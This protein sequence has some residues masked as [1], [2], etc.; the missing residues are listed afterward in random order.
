MKNSLL[1]DL[2]RRGL[3]AQT[4]KL[5]SVS[6]QL[7]AASVVYCGFDPT[8]G[9][10]HVGHLVP[11]VMLKRFAD[12]GHKAI[13][14]IG[15]A[16]GMIGDPSFKAT[17]RG[18]N[19]AEQVSKWTQS[20]AAQIERIL[21]PELNHD[22]TIV[23]NSEWFKQLDIITFFR[24]VGKHFAVNAMLNRDSVKQRLSRENQG[25]S[26][27]EFSY[28]L[29]QAYD[30]VHLNK[31]YQCTVQIGGSDQ[32]GNL[33]DGVDLTRRLN[34]QEVHGITLPLITKSDGTKFGKS[35][36]GTVWLDPNK[37]SPYA[38][39]QFWLNVAD[40]DV[41][42]FLRYYTFLSPQ[43]IDSVEQK[44]KSSGT[45]PVAQSLLAKILTRFVHGTVGLDSAERIT[46][47]LFTGDLQGLSLAEIKQLEMDGLP[48][49]P[50][51]KTKL[52]DELLVNT[53]VAGSKRIAREWINRGAIRVNGTA[54]R[55][56]AID[57][58]K[59]LFNRYFI[60]QRGKK[61]FSLARVND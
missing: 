12:A 2:H 31:H 11:L 49:M 36:T 41:Y 46:T 40:E 8:A 54:Q 9:S 32:W 38:F 5:E 50:T 44:D 35:E 27:T 28:A 18:M 34:N 17:E 33:V 1:N 57:K 60:I 7:N 16:T 21:A 23:D 51:P 30:F 43:Y 58:V 29:F 22:L 55:S 37:T 19:S 56:T 52:L 48:C 26:F 25:I 20:L 14:L 4:T 59:P 6:A 45:K 53:G 61:H 10:L 3:I 15:G 13:A 24:N 39:Y 47:A 42:N